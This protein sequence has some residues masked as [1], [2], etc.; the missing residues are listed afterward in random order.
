ME[1]ELC[2]NVSVLCGNGSEFS[3]RNLSFEQ[4]GDLLEHCP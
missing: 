1:I 2:G 3:N 4:G